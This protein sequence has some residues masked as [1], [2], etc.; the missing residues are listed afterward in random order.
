MGR[1][2]FFIFQ[3]QIQTENSRKRRWNSNKPQNLDRS[4]SVRFGIVQDQKLYS[5]VFRI[6]K[7]DS[8]RVRK[9]WFG[10]MSSQR[11]ETTV[12]RRALPWPW[13]GPTRGVPCVRM[14]FQRWFAWAAAK[15]GNFSCQI[16]G[17][18]NEEGRKKM[19]CQ[20][21]TT[22][23][24]SSWAWASFSSYLSSA[25]HQPSQ[26]WKPMRT[27]RSIFFPV[28]LLSQTFACVQHKERR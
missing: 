10:P 2:N 5:I 21:A 14:G 1:K 15:G 11:G 9:K 19:S 4:P 18:G 27:R 26:H 12:S 28:G 20:A 16:A 13:A 22:P 8:T 17:P 24:S 7:L 3:A 6:W 23:I 25:A